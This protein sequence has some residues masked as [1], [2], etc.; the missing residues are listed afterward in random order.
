MKKILM[1][2]QAALLCCTMAMAQISPAVSW[3]HS[4]GFPPLPPLKV[5]FEM[6]LFH[7]AQPSLLQVS[8]KSNQHEDADESQSIMLRHKEKN[9][10]SQYHYE[11]RPDYSKIVDT[12]GDLRERIVRK[13]RWKEDRPI[14]APFMK[15]DINNNVRAR[16][17]VRR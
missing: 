2:V 12:F 5:D 9:M 16:Y 6:N 15:M 8:L 14:Q 4:G 13:R 3:R 11:S 1:M 10:V 7:H 17:S